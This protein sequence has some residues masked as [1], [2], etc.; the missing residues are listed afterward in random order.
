MPK[1][2]QTKK[3]KCTH[4][5]ELFCQSYII[6]LNLRKATEDADYKPH[7]RRKGFEIFQKERVQNRIQELMDERSKRTQITQ[8]Y[9]VN[10]LKDVADRCMEQEN[11][12]PQAANKSLELLGKHLQV[13]TEKV[14]HT[15]SDG[16]MSPSK[17]M[18]AT[19]MATKVASIME[20]ARQRMEQQDDGNNTDS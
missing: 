17:E 2:R 8:D 3:N 1:T 11:F 13:F 20:M 19:E 18:S 15:S 4:K 7:D 16:S 9:V 10:S 5:E 14:D 6:H 12:Q